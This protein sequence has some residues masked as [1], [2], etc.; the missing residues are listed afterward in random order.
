MRN[1]GGRMNELLE[2]ILTMIIFGIVVGLTCYIL[3]MS[4]PFHDCG[5][6]VANYTCTGWGVL[7]RWNAEKVNELMLEFE[8]SIDDIWD[9]LEQWMFLKWKIYWRKRMY[10]INKTVKQDCCKYC[11][12]KVNDVRENHVIKYWFCPK[13]SKALNNT[14][15]IVRYKWK[16]NIWLL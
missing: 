10:K 15:V 5:Y 3:I 2:T 1:G 7:F 16:L 4:I 11:D 12:S 13:C 14:E 9:N 8:L 6:Q